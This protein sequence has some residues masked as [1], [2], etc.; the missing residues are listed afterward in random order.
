MALATSTVKFFSLLFSSFAIVQLAMAGDP[1]I[2]SDFVIP[3]NVTA[4]DGSFFTFTGMRALVGAAPPTALKVLKA[5]MA[6]FPALIGQSVSYAVLQYPAGTPNPPHTHPRSAELLFL[7][8]GSLQVGFVDTTSKLFT[9]TLQPG[10]LF[11]FPKGLVH[12]QYNADAK[13]PAL[14]VSAFGSANAG[15]ISLPGTLFA[16]GIDNNILATS[17]KTDVATIQALKVGLA[18]KP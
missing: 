3:S 1:D 12:F 16:T 13:N 8:Q 7:I 6:E 15:T 18:P 11:V 2:V 5:G 9:Q 4:V 10:D 17:F 14:A